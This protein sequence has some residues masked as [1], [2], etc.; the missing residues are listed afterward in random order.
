[1]ENQEEK[2]EEKIEETTPKEDETKK[3][4]SELDRADQIAERQA[5]ENDRREELLNREESLAA[6]R[7]V[8]GET[9]A[10]SKPHK[11]T[12]DEKYNRE[13][14]VRYAGTGMDPTPDDTP[15]TYS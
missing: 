5:R 2:Q 7:A 1:M 12:A 3:T 14:K 15:T 10:G 4:T 11:E 13:A 8:G 6:R 9:E